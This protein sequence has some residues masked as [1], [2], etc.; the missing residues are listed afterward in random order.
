MLNILEKIAAALINKYNPIV[1]CITGS[2]GKTSTKDAIATALAGPFSI[3]KTPKNLNNEFGVPIS[4][5]GGFKFREGFWALLDIVL[6]GLRQLFFSK[7]FPSILV[8]EV[9][10]GKVNEIKKVSQ[11]LAPSI[12]VVTTLP[13]NPSHLGVFGSKEMVIQEKRYLANAMNEKGKLLLDKRENNAKLY[14]QDFKGIIIDCDIKHITNSSEYSISY[15]KSNGFKIPFGM[16]LALNVK[17]DEYIQLSFI[18]FLGTQNIRALSLAYLVAKELG[19][20]EETIAS[21]LQKYIPEAGR[22]RILPGKLPDTVI[23]DDSFNS[24][25]I[26]V[27]NS[28]R[29]FIDIE[30]NNE[31][32]KIAVLG[33]MFN[34]GDESENIHK[35]T[36]SEEVAK[37]DVLITVGSLSEVWQTYNSNRL[38]L[39]KHFLN[40]TNAA[41]YIDTFLRGGD[42][43]LFKG[44][45]LVR[46]EK[47][48]KLLSLSAEKDLVRQ[49]EYWQKD[50][51]ELYNENVDV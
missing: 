19:Y 48:V 15:H 32:R 21:N 12:L 25:P 49:E 6:H 4:I 22:L 36:A 10:A 41:K 18:G 14:I 5:I 37:V 11:W 35:I 34:L 45:H 31:Q 23:I 2:V 1:V 46:L 38:S 7:N 17:D 42:L 8:I 33:D 43:V 40:S 30:I 24:S 29:N 13:D 51:F 47:A 26:A 27:E 3:R 20:T 44:G 39:N 50:E 16:D 9:G 28:L